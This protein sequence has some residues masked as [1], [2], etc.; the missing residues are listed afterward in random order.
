[1]LR[2]G[3]I[4]RSVHGIIEYLAGIAFIVV[5]L[6]LFESGVAT[7]VSIVVGV[8]LIVVA[9]T[10]HGSTSIIDQIPVPAHVALDFALAIFLIAAPFLFGFRDETEPLAFFIAIGI[11]HLLITIGTRF[12]RGGDGGGRGGAERLSAAQAGGG[13]AADGAPA[14]KGGRAAE[15]RRGEGGGPPSPERSTPPRG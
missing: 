7:G 5:P 13:R 9:A 8:I 2:Q 15:P 1:M 6:I 11:A 3:P 14:S 4:P 12:E 10:T